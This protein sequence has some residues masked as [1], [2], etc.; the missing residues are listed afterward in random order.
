MSQLIS[1]VSEAFEDHL[2][3]LSV[4][5]LIGGATI[6]AIPAEA[7]LAPD[8]DIGGVSDQAEGA[9]ICR[10][11]DFAIMPKIGTRIVVDSEE[12]R[13]SSINKSVGNPLVQIEYGGVAER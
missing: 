13:I 7:E 3:F 8:L 1:F 10:K 4:T 12:F 2:S 6:E 9:I 11:S 5:T